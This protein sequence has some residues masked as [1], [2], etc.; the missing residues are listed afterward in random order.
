MRAAAHLIVTPIVFYSGW[1]LLDGFFV[2]ASGQP[3]DGGGAM[4]AGLGALL[5]LPLAIAY[6]WRNRH[7]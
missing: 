6:G 5:M 2:G 7:R 4:I 1:T 3:S